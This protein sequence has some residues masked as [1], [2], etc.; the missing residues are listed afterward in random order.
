MY[1]GRGL[2]SHLVSF[3]ALSRIMNLND[4]LKAAESVLK[5]IT[6]LKIVFHVRAIGN[7]DTVDLR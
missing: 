7:V 3:L 5:K 1:E 6:M 4:I 2:H